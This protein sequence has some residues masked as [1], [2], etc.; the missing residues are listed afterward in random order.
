MTD[1]NSIRL[2]VE[3]RVARLT[4]A[5]PAARNSLTGESVLEIHDAAAR[6]AAMNEVQVLVVRGEGRD[7]CPGADVK[8][9]NAADAGGSDATNAGPAGSSAP[10]L[11]PYQ[12]TVLLHEM[13]AVTI[14]AIQGGCAGAGF[15]WACA[16]DIRVCD[17]GARFNT[18]FL[19]VGVA[20][21]M[22]VPWLLPRI[23]GA[24]V[25]RDLS[26]FPRKFDGVEADAMGL[27]SRLWSPEV[28][29]AELEALVARLAGAAP[30]ALKA[31][32]SHYVQAEGMGLADFVAVESERH[33]QLFA[34]QDRAEAFAA[35]VG[36]RAPRFAGR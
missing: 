6:V 26:F 1:Y 35:Y 18:A 14:A 5:R 19:D 36:K 31:L 9:Y 33:H 25:A 13:P 2:A 4:F 23:V 8:G 10:S 24:G 29:D 20:G 34:T 16:C 17:T 30:L 3:G 12:T 21:D 28:F 27:V 15:G 32:K 11:L 7:F 22:A